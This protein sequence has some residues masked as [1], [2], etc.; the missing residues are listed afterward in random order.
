MFVQLDQLDKI[1]KVLGSFPVYF[2]DGSLFLLYVAKLNHSLLLLHKAIPHLKSGQHC[3]VFHI[4]NKIC[5]IYKGTSS[6]FFL[7]HFI[8]SGI[9]SEIDV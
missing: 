7:S 1:F 8:K 3:Q 2:L 5:S 6:K 9:K 4:G